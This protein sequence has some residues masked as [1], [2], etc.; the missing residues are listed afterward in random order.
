MALKRIV[1]GAALALT[2]AACQGGTGD[3]AP[4][5]QG[6][7]DFAGRWAFQVQGTSTTC[8]GLGVP[9]TVETGYLEISQEG[10]ALLVEHLDACGAEVYRAPGSVSGGVAVIVHDGRVCPTPPCCY[11][12]RIKETL[13]LAGDSLEGD[14]LIAAASSGCGD[15]PASCEYSGTI[16]ATPCAPGGCES[17]PPD[18]P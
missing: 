10:T 7:A 9:S 5:S 2:L 17:Y 18:C 4:M 1:I 12:V 3:G 14:V 8:A 6:T 16:A 11:D 13:T 15:P